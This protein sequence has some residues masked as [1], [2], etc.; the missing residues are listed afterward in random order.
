MNIPYRDDSLIGEPRGY[1]IPR[2]SRG[3]A[4]LEI[5]TSFDL[6]KKL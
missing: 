2:C 4:I 3:Q 1:E 6:G 5:G